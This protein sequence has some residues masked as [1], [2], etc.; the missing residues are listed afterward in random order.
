MF[1]TAIIALAIGFLIAFRSLNK[2]VLIPSVLPAF[3]DLRTV[4]T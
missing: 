2:R 3:L 1:V 4:R